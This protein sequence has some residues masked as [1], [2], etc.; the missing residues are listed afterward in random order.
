MTEIATLFR[1]FLYRDLAFILGGLIVLWSLAYA[2]RGRIAFPPIDWQNLS[3][4]S[5]V[6]IAAAAYVIGYAVQDVGAVLPL[7]LTSTSTRFQ[8]GCLGKWLYERFSRVPWENINYV[9]P[10]ER[11]FKSQIHLERLAIPERVIQE[12]ERIRSLKVI[13]MCVGGCLYLSALIFLVHLIL[14]HSS[15]VDRVIL[16]VSALLGTCLIFLGRIKGMQEMQFYQSIHEEFC[17]GLQA[18]R[19]SPGTCRAPA[20]QARDGAARE[21]SQLRL[22]VGLSFVNGRS[23]YASQRRGRRQVTKCL[24]QQAGRRVRAGLTR[25][26]TFV[27]GAGGVSSAAGDTIRSGT[28]VA[29]PIRSSGERPSYCLGRKWTRL[30]RLVA[31]EFFRGRL[32][33]PAFQ[34]SEANLI[35]FIKTRGRALDREQV[36]NGSLTHPP[37]ISIPGNKAAI[38][39]LPIAS[40]ET[41]FARFNSAAQLSSRMADRR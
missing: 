38:G 16:I 33:D 27:C 9:A 24:E 25:L 30:P 35:E 36:S 20:T 39:D 7:R 15:V 1:Q 29:T 5:I 17:G 14:N 41:G 26:E 19:G 11:E 28:I 21:L 13:S 23:S 8:P 3:L 22:H 12:L 34:T 32:S 18:R 40:V 10:N 2:L 37:A 4:A 31:N 6:L